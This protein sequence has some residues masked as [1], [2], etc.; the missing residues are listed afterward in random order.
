MLLNINNMTSYEMK[1]S[2]LKRKD[3]AL[4]GFIWLRVSFNFN[5]I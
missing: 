4:F 5:K 1:T 3:Q 2:S